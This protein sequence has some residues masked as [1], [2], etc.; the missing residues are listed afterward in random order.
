MARTADRNAYAAKFKDPRWQRKRLEIL[1]RDNWTCQKCGATDQTLNVHHKFYSFGQDPWQ[2]PDWC[3]VTLCEEC[4]EIEDEARREMSQQFLETFARHG[5]LNSQ[6]SDLIEVFGEFLTSD[7]P[8]IIL[9]FLRCHL[10]APFDI[11]TDGKKFVDYYRT[12]K[13]SHLSDEQKEF[14]ARVEQAIGGSK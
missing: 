5:W 14:I 13:P 1:E 9:L 8:Y 6:M 2:Y 11:A 7:K 12:V 3:L 4:H 10:A